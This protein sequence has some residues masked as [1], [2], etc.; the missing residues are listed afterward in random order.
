M[1]N[2]VR[3]RLI[4]EGD[5][6]AAGKAIDSVTEKAKNLNKVVKEFNVQE[7]ADNA[8]RMIQER[9]L[10]QQ[11]LIRR[12]TIADPKIAAAR[13][14]RAD[15]RQS[16]ALGAASFS[17]FG[18][19]GSG[20]ASGQAVGSALESFGFRGAAGIA[21]IAG[22]GLA[23][24]N[25]VI[26]QQIAYRKS[27]ANEY[28]TRDEKLRAFRD[29]IPG[30]RHIAEVM[31][32]LTGTD[33]ETGRAG[34]LL[35]AGQEAQIFSTRE[36]IQNRY[37][38]EAMDTQEG[39][40]RANGGL[41]AAQQFRLPG[42]D[43]FDRSTAA[44]ERQDRESR[45]RLQGQM[46]LVGAERELV[47]ASADYNANRHKATKQLE[48][49]MALRKQYDQIKASADA[50]DEG[51]KKESHEKLVAVNSEIQ[52]MMA[53]RKKTDQD[54]E[55]LRL[56]VVTANKNR[57]QAAI[58][59]R[60]NEIEILQQRESQGAGQAQRIGSMGRGGFIAGLQALEYLKQNGAEFAS[61]EL[62]SQAASVAPDEVRKLTESAGRN[63]P[64]DLKNRFRAAAPEDAR[65]LF[66]IDNIRGAI[67]EK[68]K[69]NQADQQKLDEGAAAAAIAAKAAMFDLIKFLEGDVAGA[70]E[71]LKLQFRLNAIPNQ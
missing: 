17:G 50:G 9:A 5:A 66:D 11:E 35:K 15:A 2:E 16:L 10:L 8:A 40:F 37:V 25:M 60:Q 52:A 27:I 67:D 68:R 54:A 56:G 28:M 18:G 19:V 13:Q 42:I 57:G 4:I 64:D 58:A 47:K 41:A 24:G 38:R 62:I 70:I 14:A 49:E 26:D 7:A 53:A 45:I 29:S 20:F 55:G 65:N 44:G 48:Y 12:G 22:A 63:L 69:Q 21:G 51:S 39:V 1:S 46:Q 59:M 23:A 34:R 3:A 61:P 36:S 33:Y 31:D 30:G 43:T 71:N 6:S 32:V